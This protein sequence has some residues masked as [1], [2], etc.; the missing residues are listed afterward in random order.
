MKK[1]SLVLLA[2]LLVS[3][4]YAAS[5]LYSSASGNV[6][7]G[8][9]SPGTALDINGAL[10]MRGMAAP[11][12]SSSGQGI[13][14]F[15]STANEFEASQNGGAYTSLV[16]GGGSSQWT[17]N[18]SDIYY[19]TGYVGIGTS[20]PIAPLEVVHTLPTGTISSSGDTVTGSG[21]N[22]TSAFRAG[23]VILA[24]SIGGSETIAAIASD[25]SLTTVSPFPPLS[26][27]TAYQRLG[28]LID[29]G[30]VGIGTTLP[31]AQL[32]IRGN[33]YFGPTAGS[34][35]NQG[36]LT[37]DSSGG[38]VRLYS[39]SE[40]ILYAQGGGG[41][42]KLAISNTGT[43]ESGSMYCFTSTE[44]ADAWVGIGTV[45]PFAP[46][47]IFGSN[48]SY[49]YVARF[50]A[51]DTGGIPTQITVEG[52]TNTNQY[53]Y[54]GYNTSSNYGSIAALLSGTG[55]KPLV[56]NGGGGNVG[57]NTTTPSYP[58]DVGGSIRTTQAFL[59]SGGVPTISSCG[60]SPPAPS[61]GSNNNSGR[62][63]LGTGLPTA[64]TVTLANAFP[65][66]GFCTVTPASNYAGTYYISAQSASAFTIT[67]GTGTSS[68]VFNYT[69]GGN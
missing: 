49:G 35:L 60:T 7:V 4:A 29:A 39:P 57:V 11:S 67:L 27:G 30:Y 21:T 47:D 24:P 6:G 41:A 26:S 53:L 44:G 22:F 31:N 68:A 48:V 54:I 15:D 42:T 58:L 1:L 43:C 52:A 51:D 64:C 62:F 23:D 34:S 18:G 59:S 9:T 40:T 63:T 25:T 20:S 33:V 46:L 69:C 8:T 37:I 56:L 32:D 38:D 13:I 3:P 16:G 5:T 36:Q 65:T 17:T 50:N 19:D 61:A 2:V 45:S 66:D 55:Y 14:Y 12:V 10:T 28:A